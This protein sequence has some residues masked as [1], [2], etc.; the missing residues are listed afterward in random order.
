VELANSQL[1]FSLRPPEEDG[2]VG[3]TLYEAA[4]ARFDSSIT[5]RQKNRERQKLEM[6]DMII[7]IQD[8]NET[9]LS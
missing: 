3:G 6:L 8:D 5:Q 4:K 9:A 2:K 7:P 1:A